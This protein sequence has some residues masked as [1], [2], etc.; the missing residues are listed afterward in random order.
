[1]SRTD[2]LPAETCL[3][4]LVSKMTKKREAESSPTSSQPEVKKSKPRAKAKDKQIADLKA[5]VE[6]LKIALKQSTDMSLGLQEEMAIIRSEM[7][8]LSR[9]LSR[10]EPTPISLKATPITLGSSQ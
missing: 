9:R 5:E 2:K 4:T 8:E 1:M 7:G 3:Q 6:E 10:L